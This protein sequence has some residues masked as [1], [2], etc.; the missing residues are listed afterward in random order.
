MN[1]EVFALL[2]KL[3][4]EHVD[5]NVNQLKVI[6]GL[7]ILKKIICVLCVSRIYLG[8]CALWLNFADLNPLLSPIF[9]SPELTFYLSLPVN[10]KSIVL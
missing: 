4:K 9:F 10:K 6:T 2:I 8:L 3:T 5:D 7:K 1:N